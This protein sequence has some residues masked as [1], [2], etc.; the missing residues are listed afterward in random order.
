MRIHLAG[1]VDR[2]LV[3]AALVLTLLF[4]LALAPAALADTA[5][6]LP[7]IATL[8]P[9][10][11]QP[12]PATRAPSPAAPSPA[13]ATSPA[14]AASASP[15]A[16]P[17][18]APT[19]TP[20]AASPVPATP[21]ATEQPAP[22]STPEATPEPQWAVN[23]DT[24]Q[25]YSGP[26]ESSDSLGTLRQ[27]T[28]LQILGYVGEWA[29]VLDPRTQAT[30][31]VHS[32]VLG[33]SDAPPAY[34]FAP[35]PPAIET[36]NL[37]GRI[38][39]SAMLAFYPTHDEA[40]QT[41]KLGHNSPVTIADAVEGDDGKTWYRT[42]DGDYLPESAVRLPRPPSRTFAGRWIDADLTEPAMLTAYDGNQI[43]MDT[44]TIKGTGAFQT[45]VGLF[46]IQRRVAD[47]TMDSATLGI[48]R[49]G[50]GGYYLQ[51][52]LYTQYF[53]GDGASIHYNYWSSVWGYAGSH[54][55]LGLPL[56]ESAFLWNWANV[57]TPVWTHY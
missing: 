24:T 1:V 4:A 6:R 44:L 53:T 27:F 15:Q 11:T 47:E 9:T 55:C 2:R 50:P 22:S 51:H 32:D 16:A 37:P 57:G 25:M 3:G 20:A 41:T 34:I 38:V 52:V 48:P 10:A 54:G 40:A 5:P 30:F 43:V 12:A 35:P 14:P 19:A 17:T 33:P 23:T 18:S 45:P 13:P 26:D 29:Q 31:Y 42:S 21:A 28:Y 49:N 56:A 7:A 8:A 39:G 46:S 36:I